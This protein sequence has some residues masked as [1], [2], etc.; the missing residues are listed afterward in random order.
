[1]RQWVKLPFIATENAIFT[2]LETWPPEWHALDLAELQK[3]SA[4]KKKDD[5]KLR[6]T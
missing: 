2:V 4:Q 1:M 6:V 5:A 3:A